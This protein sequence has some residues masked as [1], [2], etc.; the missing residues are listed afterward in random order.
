MGSSSSG[1]RSSSRARR[2]CSTGRPSA[3]V[4]RRPRRGLRRPP[5]RADRAVARS[6]RAHRDVLELLYLA[7]GASRAGAGRRRRGGRAARGPGPPGVERVDLRGLLAFTIDPDDA[8]DF[9]DAINVHQEDDGLRAWVRIA[10]SR[11]SSAP[12]SALDRDAAE[13]AVGLHPG[14]VEPMLPLELSAGLCSLVPHKDRF[15]VTVEIRSGP[16][17]SPVKR[18]STG[19]SSEAASGS[20]TRMSRRS[21]PGGNEPGR[22][23]RNPPARADAS[24]ALRARRYRRGALRIR[25]VRSPSTSTE[26]AV[27]RARAERE[28][29][30]RDRRGAD[31]PRERGGRGAPGRTAS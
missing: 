20:R 21:W 24:R 19:V 13:R 18:F 3:G 25:L 26:R 15:G 4:T 30:A 27:S 16:G 28:P 1:S 22:G 2:S 12:G 5:P 9:D 31:D 29:L 23:R 11:R 14:Q 8:R 10:S 6:G 17:S 7:S